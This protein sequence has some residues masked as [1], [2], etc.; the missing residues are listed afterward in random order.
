MII[1]DSRT[2]KIVKQRILY[3]FMLETVGRKIIAPS[4]LVVRPYYV[5]RE[6]LFGGKPKDFRVES[7]SYKISFLS[8]EDVQNLDRIEGRIVTE[9]VMQDKLSNGHQCLGLKIDGKIAGF[10]WCQ[11]DIFD[12]PRAKGF[13]LREN[14]AYLYD[15]YVLRAYRGLNIAPLLRYSCYQELAKI[16]R[17]VLYSVSDVSNRPAIR[18]KKK[19]DARIMSLNLYMGIGKNRRWNVKLKTY[20]N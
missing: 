7:R 9:R 13:L 14:E 3:D 20:Y 15:M 5:F 16:G 6:G 8:N 17:T 2:F 4:G 19:L 12:F 11:L 10:T 1:F 18:F